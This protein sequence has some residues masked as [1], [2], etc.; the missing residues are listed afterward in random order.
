[1]YNKCP[2]AFLKKRIFLSITIILLILLLFSKKGYSTPDDDPNDN[3]HIS[4]EYHI[5]TES[6]TSITVDPNQNFTI[7]MEGG[8]TGA[9]LEFNSISVDNNKFT[10]HPSDYI[11]DN[12]IYDG[13]G[14]ANSISVNFTITS[15]KQRGIYDILF[16]VRSPEG[17]HDG[18]GK[19]YIA[20]IVFNIIVDQASIFDYIARFFGALLDHYNIYLGA[21]AIVSLSIATIVSEIDYRKY[22]KT[23]GRLSAFALVLSSINL[24][25]IIPES[26]DLIVFWTTTLFVDIWHLIHIVLGSVGFVACVY[27]ALKG[28]S[29]IRHRPSGYIALG[30]WGFNFIFGIIYWGVGLV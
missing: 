18:T 16:Y 15:P 13:N 27:G 5:K 20:Y 11:P 7:K 17:I 29:G 2:K 9:I 8:G 22:I 30:S 14:T 24:I 1:M 19:P 26:I 12:S 23:H 10:A 3:C 4:G 21:I 25:S 6:A 28:L